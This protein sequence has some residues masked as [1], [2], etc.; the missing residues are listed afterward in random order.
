MRVFGDVY[1]LLGLFRES[2]ASPVLPERVHSLTSFVAPDAWIDQ[3]GE[4]RVIDPKTEGKR[5][6]EN[7]LN[8]HDGSFRSVR[9]KLLPEALAWPDEL[10]FP[11]LSVDHGAFGLHKLSFRGHHSLT[12]SYD[13]VRERFGIRF[14]LDR[15]ARNG[16]SIIATR[17]PLNFWLAE[18]ER[19]WP[20]PPGP[21]YFDRVLEDV[22]PRAVA[23]EEGDLAPSWRCPSLLKALYLMLYLDHVVA[24][25]RLL[26]CQA[27]NCPDY[28]RAGPLSRDSRYCPPPPGKKQSKCASRAASA[29]YRERQRKSRNSDTA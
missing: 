14:V 23:N 18:L 4:L 29:M 16:V 26:K 11:T 5:R 13:D 8:E 17:E 15:H 22:L 6:L 24:S 19:F 9:L 25:V 7:L 1:G 2:I 27:P 12:H 3:D 20:T 10:R 21:K 28:Y